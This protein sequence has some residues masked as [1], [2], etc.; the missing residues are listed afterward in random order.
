MVEIPSDNAPI[1]KKLSSTG[2][3]LL[4]PELKMKAFMFAFFKS[5]LEVAVILFIG[6]FLLSE[7]QSF[8]YLGTHYGF[9]R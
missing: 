7:V 4:H 9:I 6:G 8:V 3:I 5:S 1:W 2:Y